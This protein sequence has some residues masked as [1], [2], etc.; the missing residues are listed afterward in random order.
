M[1]DDSKPD[2][3]KPPDDLKPNIT[4]SEVHVVSLANFSKKQRIKENREIRS[5]FVEKKP[6]LCLVAKGV[7]CTNELARS[8]NLKKP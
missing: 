7:V 4:R 1:A 5:W 2:I 8:L 3:V 6:S